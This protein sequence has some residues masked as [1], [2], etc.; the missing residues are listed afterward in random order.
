MGIHLGSSCINM[1]AI[2]IFSSLLIACSSHALGG[3]HSSP[4]ARHQPHHHRQHRVVFGQRLR[5]GRDESLNEIRS[6]PT[7]YL[8][9]AADYDYDDQAGEDD[10][11]GYK[12]GEAQAAGRDQAAYDDSQEQYGDQQLQEEDSLQGREQQEKY[13]SDQDQYTEAQVKELW[14]SKSKSS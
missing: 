14:A 1:K 2:V 3:R 10:L 11:A 13:E 12:P 7:G 5:T 8:P 6:A 4:H 9:G